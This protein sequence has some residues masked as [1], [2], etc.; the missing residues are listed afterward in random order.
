[1]AL[2]PTSPAV[3]AGNPAG[4][5][6]TVG[7]TAKVDQRGVA[8]P[9][10]AGARCDI[11][12]YEL[13][14]AEATTTAATLLGE[15]GAIL[16]G[17]AANPD[18]KGASAHFEYGRT[19]KYGKTT[20][21]VAIAALAV[22]G[23][24]TATLTALKAGTYHYRLAVTNA[25]GTVYGADRTFTVPPLAI[26][27]L[28]STPTT[29][30]TRVAVSGAGS[31]TQTAFRGAKRACTAHA[32][33]KKAST[34]TLVCR[35]NAATRQAIRAHSLNLRVTTTFTSADH[36]VTRVPSVIAIQ[37]FTGSGSAVTG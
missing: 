33:A 8:R 19:T 34:I 2:A 7:P 11:G 24:Q 21:A 29:I 23:P 27:R 16:A 6:A 35:L 30:T 37:R 36:V 31:V 18:A 26:V 28:S 9:Q 20:K 12:A 32:K 25:V 22:A 15:R 13:A 17:T 14:P 10:P 3:H 4:C 1:M 5:S